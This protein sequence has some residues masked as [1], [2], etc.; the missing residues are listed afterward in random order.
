MKGTSIINSNQITIRTSKQRRT[1][2]TSNA[3]K[4]GKQPITEAIKETRLTERRQQ[5]ALTKNRYQVLEE[6]DDSEME[7]ENQTMSK[8]TLPKNP[9]SKTKLKLYNYLLE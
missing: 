2:R 7:T 3:K 5:E 8:Q 4:E 9:K 6:G 1:T